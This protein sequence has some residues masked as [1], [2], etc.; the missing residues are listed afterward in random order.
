MI[1]TSISD[2]LAII[3]LL[4]ALLFLTW[5]FRVSGSDKNTYRL[6]D[7]VT[8][9]GRMDLSKVGQLTC[10]LTS[11]WIVVH[12]E[13]KSVVAEWALGLY[14]V[15]WVGAG[16]GSLYARIKGTTS[17]ETTTSTHTETTQ[18]PIVPEAR[19]K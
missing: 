9:K 11:T 12:M 4:F 19:N 2:P 1:E 16:F 13:L 3:G 7:L 8:T 5:L 17:S 6:S 15:A 10:L 18:S 14:M